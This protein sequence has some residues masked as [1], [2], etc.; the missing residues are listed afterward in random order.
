MNNTNSIV[1]LYDGIYKVYRLFN[2]I[3][4]FGLDEFWR[5]KASRIVFNN[6]RDKK[7]IKILDCACGCG[8]MTKHLRFFLPDSIIYGVDG[9][10]NMLEIA[11]R[12]VKG[13]IFINAFCEKLPFADGYFDA[14]VVSFAT[15]NLYYSFNSREIFSEIKRV[16]KDDGIFF[17]LETNLPKNGFVY[18]IFRV[19]IELIFF[20][21]FLFVGKD[22]KPAYLF[23][24]KT[25]LNFSS[26]KLSSEF[27]GYSEKRFNIFFNVINLVAFS[28]HNA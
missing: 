2:F 14:V 10:L 17:S 16:L 20:I 3:I 22:R 4:T 15:R 24:K 25:V 5:R 6:L 8:D 19:Y 1:S 18:F 12:R 13:V 9:N 11:K 28:R 21:I 7:N 27:L 26:D 23:L